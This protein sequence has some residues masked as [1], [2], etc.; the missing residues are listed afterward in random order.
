MVK[1][2]FASLLI[3]AAAFLSPA[4]L[5]AA[6]VDTD[7][8]YLPDAWELEHELDPYDPSDA[9]DDTDGDGLS[10][11]EEYFIDHDPLSPDLTP[12]T[13]AE[14][15]ELTA[16]KA[17]LFFWEK[18]TVPSSGSTTEPVLIPDNADFN[19]ISNS[20]HY[21][22]AAAGFAL[23][24]IIVADDRG[25]IDHEAAYTRVYETLKYYREDLQMSN[26]GD[27]V[28]HGY[29][30][31]F[32]DRLGVRTGIGTPDTSDD[33]EVSSIDHALFI[34]GAL[35]AAQYYHGTPAE[36]LAHELYFSTDWKW[37]LNDD[38]DDPQLPENQRFIRMGWQPDPENEGPVEGGNWINTNWDRYS[39]L[40]I[41]MNLAI[42]PGY[43]PGNYFVPAYTWLNINRDQVQ[44]GHWP[45]TDPPIEM[46]PHIHAGSLHNHQYSHMFLDLRNR[47]D[48]LGFDYFNNSMI[49]TLVNRRFCID[50]KTF[51][52]SKY[53]TYEENVWG[54]AA[55]N[56]SPRY[57]VMQPIFPANYGSFETEDN[58][59]SGTVAPFA[60]LGS[61]PFAPTETI[62]ALRH[63]YENRNNFPLSGQ[64]IW[65]RYGFVNCFNT[66]LAGPVPPTEPNWVSKNVIGID[67]GPI[68]GMIEN[69]RTG[70]LWKYMHRFWAVKSGLAGMTFN[71]GIVEP[72]EM[73]FDDGS[74]PN[75]FGG[76]SG[77]L[78][79]GT[80]TY[81]NAITYD[82]SS[83]YSV[84]IEGSGQGDGAWFEMRG[85]PIHQWEG[86]EFWIKGDTGEEA[87]E[88]EL[89]DTSGKNLR[90]PVS[91]YHP[92]GS[93][94][95]SWTKVK[96]PLDPFI[97][98]GVRLTGMDAMVIAFTSQGGTVWVDDIAFIEDD[99]DPIAPQGFTVQFIAPDQAKLAWD[100]NTERDV[101][102]YRIYRKGE[103][104]DDY[105]E[106]TPN[107]ISNNH[108]HVGTTF[109]D[110]DLTLDT[111]YSYY[112]TAVDSYQTPEP[113]FRGNES[114]D[115]V[116][117]GMMTK[118]T[119]GDGLDDLQEGVYG[120]TIT[121]ADTDNDGISDG[122]EVYV[123]G[124]DPLNADGD[125]D[126]T[127]DLLEVVS[128]TDPND[129]E[130]FQSDIYTADFDD[131]KTYGWT[132]TGS[133]HVSWNASS[134]SLRAVAAG[135]GS[136]SYFSPG[137]NPLLF[138]VSQV[139]FAY[140]VTYSANATQGGFRYRGMELEINPNRVG[141]KHSSTTYSKG[142]SAGVKHQVLLV[143]QPS[144]KRSSLYIDGKPKFTNKT[145]PGTLSQDWVGFYAKNGVVTLDDFVIWPVP[146]PAM[147]PFLENFSGFWG[148][149]IASL[150]TKRV[151]WKLISGQLEAKPKTIGSTSGVCRPLPLD[152][153]G[154]DCV[155]DYDVT[156]LSSAKKGGFRA[157]NKNFDVSP[158]RYAV[159]DTLIQSV[160]P[161]F[162]ANVPHRIVVA[163]RQGD[164]PGTPPTW[165]LWVDD[166]PKISAE[167]IDPV[168]QALSGGEF[169]VLF[170]D[171]IGKA[172]FDNVGI[173][174]VEKGANLPPVLYPVG[175]QTIPAN[176]ILTFDLKA[177]DPEG[178][179]LTFSADD[180]PAGATLNGQGNFNWPTTTGDVREHEITFQVSDGTDTDSEAVTI[181]VTPAP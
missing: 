53:S 59:D 73:D 141:W 92:E 43:Q 19:G 55:C 37:M 25:W 161:G 106:I 4:L 95:T 166:E 40:M 76:N 30:Y 81:D 105:L 13:D 123:Y 120:T 163:I 144:L 63:M 52:P 175:N 160:K 28:R 179:P 65:G 127:S 157:Y 3:L 66:G 67:L 87:V 110:T 156:F 9:L 61:I 2:R 38:L 136:K 79:G 98:A 133:S 155:M 11:E 119:D 168:T 151:K 86:F 147:S 75:E 100:E 10:N 94:T 60:P 36:N 32:T 115:S 114:E 12:L 21:S 42:G 153:T 72:F 143:I 77:G 180:L 24:A 54:L 142:I 16:R 45:N 139:A 34:A 108:V 96:I 167:P 102:G 51:D 47:P 85:T 26:N 131:G 14:L 39:E 128:G 82:P 27:K 35:L 181:T 64:T 56:T 91:D 109:L 97:Q 150:D 125:G 162:S 107:G 103:F 122:D 48:S 137:L 138:N 170:K 126:K 6:I 88:I 118:D 132:P 71:N 57:R 117:I 7:G 50:L 134:E 124:T 130:E 112:V 33:S 135:S 169:G 174:A 18:A 178:S 70:L 78:F 111:T 17:F 129:P 83:E 99:F 80:R 84:R 145:I 49:A 68:V 44:Y 104:D 1:L 58:N 146:S 171:K 22:V 20:G 5:S 152:I 159:L 154:K 140:T 15:L 101:V 90:V 23:A 69:H 74:D 158:Q 149:W 93:I 29:L 148:P 164:P 165:S 116:K 31:H 113:P 177:L 8:D 41:L 62:S 46:P 176:S 89:K 172:R 173:V 121:D